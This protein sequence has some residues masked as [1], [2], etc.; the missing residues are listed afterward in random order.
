MKITFLGAAQQVTGS[1]YLIEHENS[2]IL[3]DCGLFQGEKEI[4]KHNWDDFA[5][6]PSSIHAIVLTHSHLDHTG[7]IPA[8]VKKGF[9]GKIYC[10]KATSAL[11]AI[12]L[13]DSGFLQEED[14]KK[15]NESGKSS[16]SPA[17]PLYTQ[18]DAEKAITFFQSVDYDTVFAV[19]SLKIKLIQSFHIL[20]SSFVLVSDGKKTLTFSGDLG[21]PEQLIMKAPPHLQQTDFLVLESTYGDRIH[22][23]DDPIQLLGAMINDT[24]KRNGMLIIPAFAIERTQ[25]ILY[26]LYQLQQKQIIPKIPIF[27]DSPMATNVTELFFSFPEEHKLSP[28]LSKNVFNIASYVHSTEES[29]S[30][31]HHQPPVIIIAGSGMAEGGRVL[32]HFKHF[33]SDTKNTIVFVG[34]QAPGTHGYSLI[35]GVDQ[36]EIDDV[37][38]PVHA[39]IKT[40]DSFSAHADYSEILQWLSSFQTKPK[41]FLTHGQLESAQFLKKKI[42]DRFGWSVV[43]PKPLESFELDS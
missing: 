17:L 24:I 23:K 18:K 15:A 14:A 22:V 38:Y 31:D 35:N 7:Y 13:K 33:I 34:F 25:T 2:T 11:T 5:I 37:W 41:V 29:K 3:V 12:V 20:G 36:I 43:I 4:R 9:K 21:R 19:G 39:Q 16:H 27:V 30:I 40:I 28:E 32:H 8:L 26:C 10:S 6:E 42:E 1:K